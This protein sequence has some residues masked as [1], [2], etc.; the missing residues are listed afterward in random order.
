MHFGIRQMIFFVLLL[1]MPVAAYFSVFKPR[2]A[3]ID[4][5]RQEI[6]RKQA[7]LAQLEAATRKIDDLGQEIDKL[8]ESITIFEQKLP[9]QQEVEVMLQEVWK[10][11]V[12]HSLT[13]K[14]VRTDKTI[15]SAQYAELPIKMEIVGNFDGF[16]GFLLDLEQLRRITRM[17]QMTLTKMKSLEGQMSARVLLSIFYEVG[18]AGS[19]PGGAS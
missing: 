3:Q 8:A 13:P 11:A 15:I 14:S 5:A 7:K 2:N 9:A 17:P 1:G 19:G 10:L 18:G 12:R 4:E 16:Y 6:Q